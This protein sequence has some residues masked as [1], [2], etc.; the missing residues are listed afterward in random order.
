[1]FPSQSL[2]LSDLGSFR[3]QEMILISLDLSI[4]VV[5]FSLHLYFASFWGRPAPLVIV[6]VVFGIVSKVGEWLWLQRL[7]CQR[8]PDKSHVGRKPRIDLAA[9]NAS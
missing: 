1:M 3:R 8:L 6:G 4:L 2:L 5:L 9:R 7:S